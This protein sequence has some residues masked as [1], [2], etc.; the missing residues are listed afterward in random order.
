MSAPIVAAYDPFHEDRA[1]VALALAAGELTGAPVLAVAVAPAV[2]TQGWADAQPLTEE[3]DAITERALSA[4]HADL[5]VETRMVSDVSVPRALHVLAEELGPRLLVVGSTTRAH[6]GRVLPGSTAERLIAGASCP[7][8][9]A[10]RGYERRPIQTVAVG[11]AETPEGHAALEAGHALARRAGATLRVIAAV[12]PAGALDTAFAQ[13]TPPLRGIALEGHARSEHQAALAGAVDALPDGV[14]IEHELHVD[15]PAD[16]LVRVSAHV[17]VLVC[18]SR[19]YGPA[20]ALLLGGV[21]R[22]VLSAAHCPVLVLPRG[23]GFDSQALAGE[24]AA[25]TAAAT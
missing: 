25:G 14:T 18:G 8:A 6:L 22:R 19:G 17:D 9:L 3:I 21:T 7:V 13:G 23:A 10:P 16:V 11:F 12:H 2:L 5:G 15:D 1:P 24:A 20:R 4:L